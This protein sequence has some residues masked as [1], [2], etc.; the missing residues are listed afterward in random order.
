M[1]VFEIYLG[2]YARYD[3]LPR[4]R[5]LAIL[6]D[7]QDGRNR[8]DPPPPHFPKKAKSRKKNGT[9]GTKKILEKKLTDGNRLH[10]AVM[11]GPCPPTR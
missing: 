11:S 3:L 5:H 10:F 4:I 1:E 6:L 7:R 9:V 2:P 8:F